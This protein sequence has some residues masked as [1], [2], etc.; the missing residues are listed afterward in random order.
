VQSYIEITW[1]LPELPL[2][3]GRNLWSFEPAWIGDAMLAQSP[4]F[5]SGRL[6]IALVKPAISSDG[7]EAP[8]ICL[9]HIAFFDRKS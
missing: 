9:S 3:D 5:G 8:E 2:S 6:P 7:I 1:C 4:G